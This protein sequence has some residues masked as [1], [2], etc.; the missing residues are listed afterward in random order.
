MFLLRSI[1]EVTKAHQ[2]F[3][4]LKKITEY[5]IILLYKCINFYPDLFDPSNSIAGNI[6]T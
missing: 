1:S 2:K 4:L 6:N 5:L 3:F